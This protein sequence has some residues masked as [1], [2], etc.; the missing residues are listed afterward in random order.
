MSKG[1]L[2]Q[3]DMGQLKAANATPI[4]WGA[5][6]APPFDASGYVPVMGLAQ[7]HIHFLNRDANTDGQANIFVIHFAYWQPEVQMYAP[8]NNAGTFP[9][10]HGQVASFFAGD[11]SVQKRFAFIPD[12]MSNTYVIDVEKNTTTVLP[13]PP[14][15]A[16]FASNPVGL[17][18]RYSA[19]PAALVYLSPANEL[20]YL[21]VDQ[22]NMAAAT[23]NKWAQISSSELVAAAAVDPSATS[24]PVSGSASS[25]ATGMVTTR[26]TGSAT[27]SASKPSGTTSAN[28]AL[29][30]DVGLGASL[31][32]VLVGVQA[33]FMF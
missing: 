25:T 16:G 19:S 28:G 20:H 6:N 7:N 8:G 2:Y 11:V 3:A 26:A 18:G 29:G 12:D 4:E 13:P 33:W 1:N 23:G 31:V 10:K 32:A 5:T 30:L 22:N 9:Q 24:A 15:S 21:A 14:A 17:M 27:G